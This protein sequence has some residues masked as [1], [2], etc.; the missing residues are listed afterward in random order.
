KMV[1]I[2]HR[3]RSSLALRRTRG[4]MTTAAKGVTKRFS[5]A[6]L[7]LARHLRGLTQTEL[8]GLVGVSHQFIGYLETGSK[9]PND[10][11]ARALGA[12]LGFDVE[13]LYLSAPEESR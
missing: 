12:A 5:G 11:L 8:G 2:S 6:R 10:V 7:R 4:V 9:A 1:R 13:F 3:P